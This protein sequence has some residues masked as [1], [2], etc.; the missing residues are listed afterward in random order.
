MPD[1]GA[2][3]PGRQR[4]MA[5]HGPDHTNV[6][7]GLSN[8][9]LLLQA[10]NRLGEAEPLYRRALAIDEASYRPDH[11]EV[12]TDLNNL[13]S[14][15]QA[16]NRLGEAEPLY[17]RALAIFEASLGPDHPNTVTVRGNLAALE[18][19]RR[20]GSRVEGPKKGFFNRLFGRR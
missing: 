1:S 10:T 5:G 13:A 9:A 3:D 19:A 12:A 14:L 17:R 6:S 4:A 8:L 2:S 7:I 11:P 20:S 15:L 16:T 18:A